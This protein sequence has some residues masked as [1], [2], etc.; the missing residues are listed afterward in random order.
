MRNG[1]NEGLAVLVGRDG[2]E[3]EEG[4]GRGL[5]GVLDD[6]GEEEGGRGVRGLG[7]GR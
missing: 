5:V 2:Q 1:L 3:I 6:V 7:G 4:C